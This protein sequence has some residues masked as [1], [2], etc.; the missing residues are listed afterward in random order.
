MALILIRKT[1]GFVTKATIVTARVAQLGFVFEA[2]ATVGVGWVAYKYFQHHARQAD[3]VPTEHLVGIADGVGDYGQGVCDVDVIEGADL[4]EAE[5]ASLEI[6]QELAAVFD[7]FIAGLSG[8]RA[9]RNLLRYWVGRV[10]AEIKMIGDTPADRAVI[11]YHVRKWMRAK[12]YRRHAIEAMADV[13]VGLAVSGTKV[14][15]FASQLPVDS[16]RRTFAQWFFRVPNP[17]ATV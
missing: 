3:S 11:A 1:V 4:T 2:A 13:V 15:R 12:N 8:G 6:E 14:R 16:R 7:P 10:Y 9:H 5:V 17:R